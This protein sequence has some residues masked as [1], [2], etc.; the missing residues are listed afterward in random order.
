MIGALA[1]RGGGD[2]SID[3]LDI[4]AVSLRLVEELLIK[5]DELAILE[6]DLRRPHQELSH[7][8]VVERVQVNHL[9]PFD[10][11]IIVE[12]LILSE[13]ITSEAHHAMHDAV[14]H[15]PVGVAGEQVGAEPV[16]SLPFPLLHPELV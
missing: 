15:K 4:Y 16:N 1:R 11:E 6:P 14:F 5:N 12:H 8:I 13:T 7:I 2:R 3:A 10:F 9:Q